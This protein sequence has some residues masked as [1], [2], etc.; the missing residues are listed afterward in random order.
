[1]A[2]SDEDVLERIH[3]AIDDKHVPLQ[4]EEATMIANGGFE[5]LSGCQVPYDRMPDGAGQESVIVGRRETGD[6]L[7]TGKISAPPK[8]VNDKTLALFSCEG[9]MTVLARNA[10]R[11]LYRNDDASAWVAADSDPHHYQQYEKIAV[12]QTG[13][14]LMWKLD[15]GENYVHG[16]SSQKRAGFVFWAAGCDITSIAFTINK[17]GDDNNFEIQICQ[18]DTG[19]S[20]ALNV[21]TQWGLGGANPDGTTKDYRLTSP[22]PLVAFFVRC[23]TDESNLGQV[24]RFWLTN[25]RVRGIATDDS[26]TTSDI[27]TDLSNRCDYGIAGIKATGTLALPIDWSDQWTGLADL[28][29]ERDDWR[30]TVVD[31]TRPWNVYGRMD[32]DAWGPTWRAHLSHGLTEGLE[33][34]PLYNRAT[35]YY[36]TKAGVLQSV[37]LDADPSDDPLR[38]DAVTR[39][40]PDPPTLPDDQPD[41]TLATTT[42][43]NGLNMVTKQRANGPVTFT[44]CQNEDYSRASAYDVKAG[45]LFEIPDFDPKLPAQRIVSVTYRPTEVE[46]QLGQDISSDAVI[47]R[48]EVTERKGHH[49]SHHQRKHR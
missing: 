16:T 7:W 46:A 38:E 44:H 11:L 45:G 4:W 37:T 40:W 10:S 33:L 21:E 6:I 24:E 18:A 8:I 2:A 28:M 43:Q 1:M 34:Q 13:A 23:I 26:M 47:A 12:Q 41:K 35:V 39:E 30:W 42:A 22:S 17:S 25:V 29:S 31:A 3:W 14:R 19:P 15:K 32:Y 5:R 27:V 49:R 36:T 20:G 9:P 48:A